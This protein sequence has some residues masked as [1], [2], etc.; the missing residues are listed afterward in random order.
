MR[1]DR[2]FAELRRIVGSP[3]PVRVPFSLFGIVM[4]FQFLVYGWRDPPP[5]W[6]LVVFGV[7]YVA[8]FLPLVVRMA[9]VVKARGVLHGWGHPI[10]SERLGW[11]LMIW[12]SPDEPR[13]RRVFAVVT[14]AC[15]GV[16]STATFV[17]WGFMA[18]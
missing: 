15:V 9:R 3:L 18:S 1:S 16:F 7:M 14:L 4:N 6:F 13:W 12:P 5:T 11:W 17:R 2:E 10:V 8:V